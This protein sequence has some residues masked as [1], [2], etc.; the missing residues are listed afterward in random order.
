M[1]AMVDGNP[2]AAALSPFHGSVLKVKGHFP[3]AAKAQVINEGLTIINLHLSGLQ[4]DGSPAKI[5]F[6]YMSA[7]LTPLDLVYKEIA[8]DLPTDVLVSDKTNWTQ[9]DTRDGIYSW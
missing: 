2:N 1:P 7:F 3:M 4:L 6:E 8:F 5:L 9:T